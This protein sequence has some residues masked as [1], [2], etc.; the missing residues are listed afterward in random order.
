ME[1]VEQRV[2]EDAAAGGAQRPAAMRVVV[3]LGSESANIAHTGS[4]NKQ[5]KS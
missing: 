1:V 3:S 4:Q 5:H 2:A